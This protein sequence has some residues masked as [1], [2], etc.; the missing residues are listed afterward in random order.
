MLVP[1]LRQTPPLPS[2]PRPIVSI[3][4]GGIVRNA[5]L[6]AYRK[7]GWPVA[8]VYDVDA[9][10]AQALARDF[11]IPRVCASME[12]AVAT[13]PAG[14]VFDLALP[15]AAILGVLAAIP[16]GAPV[17]IQKPLGENLEQATAIRDACRRRAARGRRQPPAAV[18]PKHD[19]GA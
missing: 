1:P 18:R 8:S 14:A 12:E 10:R 5:H 3:G 2:E 9:A 7:A 16:D 13:A 19:R 4:A 6:P 17:L 15:A 11:A